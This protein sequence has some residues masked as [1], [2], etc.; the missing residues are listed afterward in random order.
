M[1][2]HQIVFLNGPRRCGKDTA[3]KFIAQE[4]ALESRCA[5][6]ATP[7]KQATAALFSLNQGR[8]RQLE[9]PGSELKTKPLPE[10][11][12]LSWVETLIWLSEQC[13]KPKFGKDAFGLLML[14]QLTQPT[15]TQVTVISD[16][17]FA[18]EMTPLIVFYGAENCHLFRIH[19]EGCTFDGDSRSYVF[20]ND[21]PDGLHIDDIY[22]L[23]D[24]G[25]YR[26]QILRRIDK[27]LGRQVEYHI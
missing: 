19:R 3:A 27:I 21:V 7:L 2:R 18:E 15:M 20:E 10:L 4:F 13:V 12:G 25:M 1:R 6:F 5:K 16:C 23:H 17:G 8:Y 26:V 22:N 24:M 14:S 11:F 9:A